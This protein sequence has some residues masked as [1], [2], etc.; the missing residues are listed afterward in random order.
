[1][2]R[3]ISSIFQEWFGLFSGT[4]ELRTVSREAISRVLCD[5]L[6]EYRPETIWLE[7]ATVNL[8]LQRI[9]VACRVPKADYITTTDHVT[10]EQFV[11]VLSQASFLLFWV[12]AKEG[13]IPQI[14]LQQMTDNADRIYYA[15]DQITYRRLENPNEPF[16]IIIGI[17]R[18][19][20]GTE[21]SVAIVEISDGPFVGQT[22]YFYLPAGSVQKSPSWLQTLCYELWQSVTAHL[23]SLKLQL[24]RSLAP[25]PNN[26]TVYHCMTVGKTN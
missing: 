22:T 10:R 8:G 12:M 15:R 26:F 21:R 9:Q 20:F 19:R 5:E 17:N 18:I 6:R 3:L 13:K 16:S 4:P 14:N 25:K 24:A 7:G 23:Q 11:R 1:M 2:Q